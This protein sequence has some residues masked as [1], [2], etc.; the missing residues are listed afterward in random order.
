MLSSLQS[1][2]PFSTVPSVIAFLCTVTNCRFIL[3][4]SD[5]VIF[6]E[7]RLTRG[8][9]LGDRASVTGPPIP[10]EAAC[11]DMIALTIVVEVCSRV[12]RASVGALGTCNTGQNE[13]RITGKTKHTAW[14]P[15]FGGLMFP[16]VTA[17]QMSSAGMSSSNQGIVNRGESHRTIDEGSSY[18]CTRFSNLVAVL[19]H[20]ENTVK[21][22]HTSLVDRIF[23][24]L[25]RYSTLVQD[26]EWQR[27]RSTLVE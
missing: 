20:G 11:S 24:L 5:S 19:R 18:R 14:V 3:C 15:A 7:G 6:R 9:R 8:L 2:A 10:P 16:S 12:R 13:E 23:H 27:R 1:T 22:E 4:S 17:F 21:E 26:P 25:V